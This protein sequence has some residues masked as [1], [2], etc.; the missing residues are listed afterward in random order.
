MGVILRFLARGQRLDHIEIFDGA[1]P[2]AELNFGELPSR[3]R[4]AISIPQSETEHLLVEHLASMGHEV[5]WNTTLTGL[6]QRDDA[7]VA[8]LLD[9]G[10]GSETLEIPWLVGCD[11]AHSAVRHAL[12]LEFEGEQYP[13]SFILAD[14]AMIPPIDEHRIHLFL[15]SEGLLG[16]FPYGLGRYRIVAEA[17]NQ[18]ATGSSELP[19]PDLDEIRHLVWKRSPITSEVRDITWSSRFQISARKITQFHHGRVFLCGDA[20]HIHSPAGGQ[21]MNTGIQDAFNLGW[22]LAAFVHGVS[23][24]SLLDSYHSEREPVARGVL[25]FT[26]R[27][28]HAATTHN[29]FLQHARN[30]LIPLFA[31]LAS[32]RHS[33]EERLAELAIAYRHSPI[34]SGHYGHLYGGNRMPDVQLSSETAK[35]VRLYE[36][37]ARERKPLLLVVFGDHPD[38]EARMRDLP[39]WFSKLVSTW[40][41]VPPGTAALPVP[42]LFDS[43]ESF[44]AATGSARGGML[45]VRPDAY[46]GFGSEDWDFSKL[47]QHLALSFPG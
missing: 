32:A 38:P 9:G 35:P 43:E 13:Q 36:L 31:G 23:P 22:K 34:V 18:V 6:R 2:L 37:I 24:A 10:G 40:A 19:P 26:D 21:G 30:L 4:H 15:A 27:L 16:I 5:E 28:T 47:E 20:A 12:G 14:A 11:G 39:N 46:V 3:Y 7:A 29:A 1:R 41:I 42:T 33:M 44:I 25:H 8:T 45:L 17:E